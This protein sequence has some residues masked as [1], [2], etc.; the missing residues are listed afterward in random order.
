V[1]ALLD[2]KCLWHGPAE[3]FL[4]AERLQQLYQQAFVFIKHPRYDRL[5]A[6]ADES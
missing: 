2:G 3:Q 1:L 6:L 4:N 5:I